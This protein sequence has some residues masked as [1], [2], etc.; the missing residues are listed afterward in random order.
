M[1]KFVYGVWN[2]VTTPQVYLH[3]E[4]YIIFRFNSEEDTNKIIQQGPYKFQN[5][6]MILNQWEPDF[7]LSEEM[8]RIVPI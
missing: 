4:G 2:S 5:I 6:P 1:L 7:Q 8:T 3:D